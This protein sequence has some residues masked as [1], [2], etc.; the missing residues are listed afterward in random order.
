MFGGGRLPVHKPDPSPAALCDGDQTK[1]CVVC[2]CWLQIQVSCWDF[3]FEWGWVGFADFL[4]VKLS[5]KWLCQFYGQRFYETAASTSYELE[6]LLAL[7]EASQALRRLK[8]FGEVV[9]RE[10]HQPNMSSR[11][12]T[13]KWKGLQVIT[14]SANTS[15]ISKTMLRCV[16]GWLVTL[17]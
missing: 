14:A 4:A 5:Q 3:P 17:Q 2:S 8:V 16:L 15:K 7:G 6:H 12:Q 10:R 11:W 13:C 1:L 9:W